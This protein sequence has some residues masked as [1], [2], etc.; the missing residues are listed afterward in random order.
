M[1]KDNALSNCLPNIRG[2]LEALIL[3]VKNVI[4]MNGCT[5]ALFMGIMKNI[6]IK[7]EEILSQVLI[8]LLCILLFIKTNNFRN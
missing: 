7:G 5:E 1:V 4:V 6:D 3:K 2:I 8:L